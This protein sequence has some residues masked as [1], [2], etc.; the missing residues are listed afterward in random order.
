MVQETIRAVKEAEEKAEKKLQETKA[1]CDGILAKAREDAA[2]AKDE[3]K[4]EAS[5]QADAAMRQAQ[6]KGQ[7]ILDESLKL[8]EKEIAALKALA[9]EK[10]E[11]AVGVVISEL[12]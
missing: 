5:G 7:E 4:K 6:A 3:A 9:G 11:R 2:A 8:A 10:E 1:R 12:V